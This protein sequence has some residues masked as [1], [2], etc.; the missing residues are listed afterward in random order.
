MRVGCGT[1]NVMPGGGLHVD[2]VREADC[3]LHLVGALRL[4]AVA[5]PDDLE[6]FREAV[7]HTGDHVRDQRPLQA[8]ERAI[9][10]GVIDALDRE[11]VAVTGDGDTADDVVGELTLRA[12]HGDLGAVD[13][14]VDTARDR[15]RLLSNSRHGAL[16]YQ[17][18]HK[19]L[20]ADLALARLTVGQ[21]AQIRGQDRDTHSP[22]STRGTPSAF[23]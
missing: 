3:D 12:L 11:R 20:A 13:R 5:D 17:T 6:V 22:P 18:W 21:Q 19:T 8:V 23:E 16:R 2:G 4:G 1:S 10:A 7:G 15:D 9:F 14:H